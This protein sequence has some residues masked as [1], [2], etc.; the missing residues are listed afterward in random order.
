MKISY[1]WYKYKFRHDCTSPSLCQMCPFDEEEAFEIIILSF[2]PLAVQMQ[3][4]E[5]R[6]RNENITYSTINIKNKNHL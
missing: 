1:C 6:N 5:I 2:R 4:S 3:E